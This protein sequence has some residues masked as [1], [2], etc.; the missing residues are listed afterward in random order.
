MN[1]N[2]GNRRLLRVPLF[3]AIGS[4]IVTSLTALG[5]DAIPSSGTGN[6]DDDRA[7]QVAEEVFRANE[8]WWKRTAEVKT[9]FPFRS[10]LEFLYER[11]LA[12]VLNAIL[13]VLKW[14]LSWFSFS[15]GESAGGLPWVE[16]IAAAL[17]ILVAWW[18]YAIFRRR[19]RRVS[20]ISLQTHADR[21]DVLPRF[22]QLLAEARSTLMQGDHRQAIR[23]TFLSMLAWLQ[24]QGKLR[25]DPARSNREY[26]RDL[27]R[28]PESVAG[29][30]LAA[31]P[32]ERCWYGGRD[33]S[34]E[35]VLSVISFCQT[36]YQL[37]KGGE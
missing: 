22:D 5:L 18:G 24:D 28:W 2:R 31:E 17:A 4:G 6:G 1:R 16:V 23:F 30:R 21:L 35:Q 20:V 25:Y 36:Q 13:D 14:I 33:L 7:H 8:Y 12:P 3:T 34:S 32:F 19:G 15:S 29:F 9:N 11:I 27:L 10:F 37:A 26:Q